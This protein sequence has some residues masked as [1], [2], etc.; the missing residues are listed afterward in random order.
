MP[1]F[2]SLP[3]LSGSV[4][5]LQ[6]FLK[7]SCVSWKVSKRH[8][9]QN[10]YNDT[11]VST[12]LKRKE[13][14]PGGAPLVLFT[15]VSIPLLAFCG[16]ACARTHTHAHNAAL[17]CANHAIKR[18]TNDCLHF[19]DECVCSWALMCECVLTCPGISSRCFGNRGQSCSTQLKTVYYT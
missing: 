18:A 13:R 2:F 4:T 12:Q 14:Q 19:F 7:K 16:W 17:T 5:S 10:R 1:L 8:R 6:R 3:L 15:L 11:R 9:W